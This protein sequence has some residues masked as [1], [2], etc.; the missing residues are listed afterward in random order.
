MGQEKHI[1]WKRE[2]VLLLMYVNL[3]VI[4]RFAFFP[5]SKADGYIQ[6]LIFDAATVFPFSVNLLPVVNLLDKVDA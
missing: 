2:A 6:P 3:A 5:M 1:D 4:I